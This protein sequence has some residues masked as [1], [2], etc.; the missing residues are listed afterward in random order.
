MRCI[1]RGVVIFVLAMTNLALPGRV[2][3]AD[4]N[5]SP[6]VDFNGRWLL[7]SWL[8]EAGDDPAGSRARPWIEG[9]LN[10]KTDDAERV[11]GGL[12]VGKGD[13]SFVLVVR[14]RIYAGTREVPAS[15]SLYCKGN[16]GTSAEEITYALRGWVF[17]EPGRD[18]KP[19]PVSVRGS[20]VTY[21][22]RGLEGEKPG[23]VGHF[24]L[25]PAER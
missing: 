7:R 24:V 6:R 18:G 19:G 23:L 14:G 3:P 11:K 1:G 16:T 25:T 21:P 13:K 8:V 4:K 20:V 15:V 17:T 9:T 5:E 12:A 2:V 22:G 10:V